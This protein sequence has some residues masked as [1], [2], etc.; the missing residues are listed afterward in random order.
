MRRNPLQSNEAPIRKKT[1][2]NKKT[3]ALGTAM[4]TLEIRASE[5]DHSH[6]EGENKIVVTSQFL[7]QFG[8]KSIFA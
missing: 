4:K 5:N 3:F 7:T 1:K 8:S 6:C 2:L